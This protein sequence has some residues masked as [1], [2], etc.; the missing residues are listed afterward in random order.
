[1]SEKKKF[2]TPTTVASEYINKA[3]FYPSVQW[4]HCLFIQTYRQIGLMIGAKEPKH[5]LV[6]QLN[7]NLLPNLLFWE[8]RYFMLFFY[9]KLGSFW[10][11]SPCRTLQIYTG[12]FSSA[13]FTVCHPKN[14]AFC[15]TVVFQQCFAT[16]LLVSNNHIRA[17]SLSKSYLKEILRLQG[18]PFK[19]HP[20][21]NITGQITHSWCL[22]RCLG[23]VSTQPPLCKQPEAIS[24]HFPHW[25]ANRLGCL[26]SN[27]SKRMA[28]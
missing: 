21:G 6:L 24:T 10:Y 23:S 18:S 4:A 15:S 7:N 22:Q 14:A 1:M 13:R 9:S 25:K 3:S 17:T 16:S 11:G 20:V 19:A 27:T 26:H 5:I 28:H 2:F 12:G 8:N